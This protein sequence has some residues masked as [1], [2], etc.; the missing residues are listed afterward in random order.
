[1][2]SRAFACLVY[3]ALAALSQ[4][5]STG[6]IGSLVREFDIDLKVQWFMLLFLGCMISIMHWSE[7]KDSY[8]PTPSLQYR[9]SVL[10]RI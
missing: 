10:R 2:Y 3:Q 8:R 1:M 4:A 9:E 6:Y 5:D 7:Q